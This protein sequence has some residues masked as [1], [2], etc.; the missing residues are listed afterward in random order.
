MIKARILFGLCAVL[1]VAIL[2]PAAAADPFEGP[3]VCTSAG[4]PLSG[5]HGNLTVTGNAYVKSGTTLTVS[6]NLTVARGAC[7]DAFT[8]GTVNVGGNVLVGR[9]AILGLGCSE[10]AIGP[11]PPCGA[12]TTSDTVGGSILANQPLTM[13]LTATRIDG[14]VISIGGGPGPVFDPYI[15]YSIKENAIGGNLLVAGW[16]GAWFGVIRNTID[17]SAVVLHNVGVAISREDG[18]PDSNEV[19][20]NT[21][22]GDLICFANKPSVQFGDSGGAPNAVGGH[23]IGQ[24][25]AV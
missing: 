24:C 15:N 11:E 23:K 18:L 10:G 14:S 20:T 7:L 16:A 1:A 25:G 17:G 4:T 6:G 2:A 21:I 12:E 3:P 9:G 5:S 19:V 8:L 13:Y 22:G